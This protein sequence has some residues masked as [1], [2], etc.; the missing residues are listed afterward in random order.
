[1]D[2]KRITNIKE[3]NEK[4]YIVADESM[5]KV[6]SPLKEDIKYLLELVDKMAESYYKEHRE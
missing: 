5:H 4:I 1:V 2:P 3:R 6:L